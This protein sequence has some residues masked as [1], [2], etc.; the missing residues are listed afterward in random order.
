MYLRLSQEDKESPGDESNSIFNQRIF[1]KEYINKNSAFKG[2]DIIEFC[3]DGYSGTSMD[4]PGMSRMLVQVE[5]NNIDCIIVK[6][7]SRFSRDYIELGTYIYQILPSSGVRLI[8]I[9]DNYDSNSHNGSTA[10]MDT[11]FKTL[12]YDLY[13]KDISVKVKASLENKC[14]KGEYVFGQ[15]PFGY[16][17]SRINKNVIEIN[18]KEAE[19]VRYIFSLAAE[20]KSSGQIAKKLYS[21]GIPPIQELRNKKMAEDGRIKTWSGSAI[22]RILSNRFYLGEMV[23]GKTARKYP[24]SRSALKIP[25]KDWKVIKRHHE[26][27]VSEEIFAL[28]AYTK[29][30]YTTKCQSEGNTFKGKLFCG[31]CGY[32]MS[33]KKI[34]KYSKYRHFW[35]RK[36]SLLQIPECCTNYNADTLEGLVLLMLNKEISLRADAERH[37][38]NLLLYRQLQISI[39][40]KQMAGYRQEQKLLQAEKDLLYESYASGYIS[41]EEYKEKSGRLTEKISRLSVLQNNK[42]E[43]FVHIEQNLKPY[44][45]L[46][47]MTQDIADIFI[48]KIYVFKNKTIEIEWTFREH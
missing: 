19:I 22:R 40:K 41:R 7:L 47:K 8:A 15:V 46:R 35:C 18:E 36:H 29:P 33:Y 42:K 3:D 27:L 2:Y 11:E 17:K 21:G 10:G 31:G 37:G 23:Y 9:N 45:N 20:G 38:K 30:A 6:D 39:L 26:A 12:L 44:F 43:E 1:I 13:S 24:G 48:K 16:Q 5:S 14:A 34:S 32:S 25:E 4:R 28:A